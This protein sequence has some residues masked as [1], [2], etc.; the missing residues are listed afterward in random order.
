MAIRNTGIVGGLGETIAQWLFAKPKAWIAEV[1][2]KA[3]HLPQTN[4]DLGCDFAAAGNW[5]DA[6]FRF[7]I[8]IY[9]QPN[10]PKAYYN[11]GCCYLQLNKR[12]E[13]R[14]A[15]IRTLAQDP[16]HSDALLML[17]ALD[18]A[19]VAPAQRPTRM[20]AATIVGFFASIA[21][22]Y[23]AIET[24]NEYRGGKACWEALKPL[25][26][27]RSDLRIL[28][29]GCGTGLASRP[30]RSLAAE[31]TGIDFTPAMVQ[32]AQQ[33]RAGDRLAFDTVLQEDILEL[34]TSMAPLATTDIVLCCN[35]AQFVG[36]LSPVLH[37]LAAALPPQALVLLTTEPFNTPAGYGMNADT[38]RFGHHPNYVK[39][40]AQQN[41]FVVKQESK[42]QLYPGISI[43]MIILGR[44]VA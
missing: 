9:F 33:A 17:S 44:A 18:P 12:A 4:F 43:Q 3:Q 6:I 8:A 41:G 1:T 26:G 35:V 15:F 25:V 7:R 21:D 11:L 2:Y 38:G 23:D 24:T 20:P 34:R 22:R 10:F 14:Q 40:L 16:N 32:A 29:L 5:K 31:I 36:D 30:W 28:D 37:A 27:Q 13:A 42:T 19:A 39:Q